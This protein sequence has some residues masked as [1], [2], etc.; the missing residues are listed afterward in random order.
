MISKEGLLVFA[1]CVLFCINEQ[2]NVMFE[3]KLH[4][5]LF[6]IQDYYYNEFQ[7]PLLSITFKYSSYGPKVNNL[8]L[9]LSSLDEKELIKVKGS[10][11]GTKII[12][13]IKIEKKDYSS[14]ERIVL[15]II[16]NRYGD[17][18]A[19]KLSLSFFGDKTIKSK[20]EKLNSLCPCTSPYL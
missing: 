19:R 16:M 3:G 18:S 15:D 11:F 5:L 10:R 4:K 17:W 14:K 8:L 20:I 6:C 7:E 12:P 9:L 1:K 13:S 2:P